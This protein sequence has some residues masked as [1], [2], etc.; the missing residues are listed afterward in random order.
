MVM[1]LYYLATVEIK[2]N[3]VFKDV[4]N[5]LNIAFEGFEFCEDLSGNFEEVPA[6]VATKGSITLSLFGIPEGEESDAYIL[7]LSCNE[8][9]YRNDIEKLIKGMPKELAAG[10]NGYVDI[11]SYLASYI[12]SVGNLECLVAE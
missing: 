5:Q 12:S 2:A 3:N 4:A 6:F 1:K 9:V 7:E 10:D 11:S 8:K